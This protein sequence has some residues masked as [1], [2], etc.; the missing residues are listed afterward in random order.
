MNP[1]A[2]TLMSIAM[3]AAL[4]LLIFGI[5]FALGTEH[6]KQ[7]R[8]MVLMAVILVANVLIWTV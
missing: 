2:A 7:G 4:V 5:K 8:L 3:L 1:L 6:R